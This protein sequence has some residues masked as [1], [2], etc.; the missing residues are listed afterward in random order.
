[1]KLVAGGNKVTFK[2]FWGV[3]H[4]FMHMT[5]DLQQARDYEEDVAIA[6]VSAHS[7]FKPLE[8]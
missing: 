2:R 4:P 8:D 6:L 5:A 7:L 3:P 1:M